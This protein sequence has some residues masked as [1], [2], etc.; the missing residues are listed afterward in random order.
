MTE[1]DLSKI[2]YQAVLNL[3][4]RLLSLGLLEKL[5]N[6]QLRFDRAFYSLIWAPKWIGQ[7]DWDNPKALSFNYVAIPG[8]YTIQRGLDGDFI[9]SN[10]E[11]QAA[12]SILKICTDYYYSFLAEDLAAQIVDL[13]LANYQGSFFSILIDT[14]LS[15]VAEKVISSSPDP[16]KLLQKHFCYLIDDAKLRKEV[17]R[18]MI[19]W[20]KEGILMMDSEERADF[21]YAWEDSEIFTDLS[22]A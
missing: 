7:P 2:E 22:P 6:C 4:N 13:I 15:A 18:V 17:A 16:D 8:N 12:A 5:P 14:P 21:L 3:R 11:E 10:S 9:L 19:Q 1:K 20:H